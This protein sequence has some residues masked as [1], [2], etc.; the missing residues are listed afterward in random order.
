M[1]R[2]RWASICE[3]CF[4]SRIKCSHHSERPLRLL[5]VGHN[6]SDHAWGSGFAYSNPSNR[7]WKVLEV[8]LYRLCKPAVTVAALASVATQ[9]SFDVVLLCAALWLYAIFIFSSS[10]CECPLT[11]LCRDAAIRHCAEG[12]TD[13][14]PE[15]DAGHDRSRLRGYWN[16]CKLLFDAVRCYGRLA[17][18]DDLGGHASVCDQFGVTAVSLHPLCVCLS[19]SLSGVCSCSLTVT[20]LL[21]RM[22]QWSPGAL[23]STLGCEGT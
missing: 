13:Q 17:S 22:P 2:D 23:A 7:M 3:S 15:R 1:Y 4:R 20:P 19:D 21:A 8:R 6:P 18:L 9:L 14:L 11:V 5:L 16:N 12:Q 10:E